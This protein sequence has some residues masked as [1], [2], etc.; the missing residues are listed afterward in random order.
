MTMVLEWCAFLIGGLLLYMALFLYETEED[1]LQRGI[2]NAWLQI[3]DIRVS[4][5]RVQRSFVLSIATRLTTWLDAAM[6]GRL[7]SAPAL[8][9]SLA[10]SL[11]SLLI[12]PV[13]IYSGGPFWNP[14]AWALVLVVLAVLPFLLR[15]PVSRRAWLA[16][17]LLTELAFFFMY[18]SWMGEFGALVY[19]PEDSSATQLKTYIGFALGVASDL[20]FIGSTRLLFRWNARRGGLLSSLVL[21]A[22]ASAFPFL[23]IT[24]PLSIARGGPPLLRVV[25]FITAGSNFNLLLLSRLVQI[26]GV[27]LVFHPL[28]WLIG[29]RLVYSA[30]RFGLVRRK[31][32]LASLAVAF[33]GFASPQIGGVIK[34]LIEIAK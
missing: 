4:A 26:V 8:A 5:M 19:F 23:V 12:G 32:V 17:C 10:L 29:S 3:D 28:L 20:A 7:L 24:L 33:M 9:V 16:V 15:S 34:R 6:G 21:L 14:P 30:A 1:Q 11:A 25:G 18:R 22:V 31:K 13:T 27:L 2:E